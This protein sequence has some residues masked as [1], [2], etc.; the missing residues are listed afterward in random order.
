MN[1]AQYF[2]LEGVLDAEREALAQW[3][4]GYAARQAAPEEA[5]VK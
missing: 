2:E 3:C 5:A 4:K 1:N